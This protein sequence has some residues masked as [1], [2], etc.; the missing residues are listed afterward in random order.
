M[1]AAEAAE[2]LQ[3]SGRAITALFE[4]M[5]AAQAR[6]RPDEESWSALEVLNHL[7]DEEREDFRT[8]LRLT[9]IEPDE[10]WPPID[11]R[12]WVDERRY[13]ERDPMTSLRNFLTERDASLEWLGTLVEPD[14]E[15]GR[16]LPFGRLRAGDLLASWCAHDLLHL[17]QLIELHYA[18]LVHQAAPYDV[19]Y[20]G[21][22]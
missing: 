19:R 13:N 7:Y 11:P 6:W 8:R 20:A 21:D 2:R 18:Y 10:P 14:W 4:G 17:R 16:D 3:R 12:G 15:S 1:N 22:W 9:L 5:D